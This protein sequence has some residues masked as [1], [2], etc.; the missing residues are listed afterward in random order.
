MAGK[1]D[2]AL[3]A[4]V[5]PVVSHN[6]IGIIKGAQAPDEA[7]VLMAHWDHMGINPALRATRS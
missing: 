1:A 5:E 4:E 3:D 7:V 6:L 2:I